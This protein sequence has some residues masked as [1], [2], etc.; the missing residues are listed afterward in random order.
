MWC[1][2]AMSLRARQVRFRR[3][4]PERVPTRA[5]QHP[6]LPS[7]FHLWA[8]RLLGPVADKQRRE[9]VIHLSG[10]RGSLQSLDIFLGQ[11]NRF[12]LSCKH[13]TPGG[14]L[15]WTLRMTGWKTILTINQPHH[16]RWWFF[17]FNDFIQILMNQH[18]NFLL[19]NDRTFVSIE[20]D[21]DLK[22]HKRSKV[23]IL[24]KC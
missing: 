20:W 10:V 13:S 11:N 23:R 8:A 7:S 2:D 4:R 6:D 17:S 21:G 15:S 19:F 22:S 16:K 3:R 12:I 14:H 24:R 5:Q 18:L 9:S 1:R